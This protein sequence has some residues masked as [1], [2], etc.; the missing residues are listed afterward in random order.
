MAVRVSP[1][2]EKGVK[3]EEDVRVRESPAGR[4]WRCGRVS[5]RSKGVSEG[6]LGVR[7]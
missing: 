2:E 5:C 3:E 1:A 7:K 4:V 6:S